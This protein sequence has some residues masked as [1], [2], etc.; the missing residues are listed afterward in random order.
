MIIDFSLDNPGFSNSI[1]DV[2]DAPKSSGSSSASSGRPQRSC[3]RCYSRMS[4]IDRDKH[5]IDMRC[6]DYEC[7]VNLR[8]EECENWSKEEM[9]VH[10]KI[11]K[12][13]ASKSISRGKS[14]TKAVKKAASPLKTSADVDLDNR[15]AAQYG[16]MLRRWMIGC[17][18]YL[19]LY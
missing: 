15:F 1:T 5:L 11:H 14:S 8:C 9:L 3:A 4:N 10:E 16:R 17:N 7:S 12:S 6:R 19:R 18:S 2:Q 13:L